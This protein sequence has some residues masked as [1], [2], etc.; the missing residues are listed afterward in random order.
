MCP[1]DSSFSSTSVPP[2]A[3]SASSPN[4]A[5]RATCVRRKSD[6]F[7]SPLMMMAWAAFCSSWCRA[8]KLWQGCGT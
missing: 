3:A 4:A 2:A 1:L 7:P 8:R 5:S 6:P